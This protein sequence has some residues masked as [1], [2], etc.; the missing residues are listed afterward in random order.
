MAWLLLL[1][2][3]SMWI[4]VLNYNNNGFHASLCIDTET[5]SLLPDSIQ[6]ITIPKNKT[7]EIPSID[8]S[9]T[10]VNDDSRPNN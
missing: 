5:G 8:K 4:N 9:T 6:F 7:F 2:Y 1:S 10:V 3:D